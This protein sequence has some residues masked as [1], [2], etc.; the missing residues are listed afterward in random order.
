MNA[1]L[2]SSATT[3]RSFV[4]GTL[5]AGVA[6]PVGA[7]NVS[8]VSFA[9]V[10]PLSG[11]WARGGQLLLAGAEMAVEEINAAGGIR[12]LNGAKV[13]LVSADAGD[14]PEKAKSAIQRLISQEPRLI[15]G[16]GAWLSSFTLAVTEVT[17]RERLPWLTLSYADPVTARG[18]RYV[19]QTSPTGSRISA[20]SIPGLLGVLKKSGA[21]AI[22][23][24]AIVADNTPASQS[25]AKPLADTI[26]KANGLDLVA[27]ETYSPPLSDA[28]AIVRRVRSAAADLAILLTSNV[29]DMKLVM[30]KMAEFKINTKLV[31]WGGGGHLGSPELGQNINPGLLDGL[32]F[33]IPNWV[34]KGQ[35]Q[36]ASKFIARSKEPFMSQDPICGY[37]D[38]WILKDA[39]E[40]AGTVDRTMIAEQMHKMNLMDGPA[41][42]AY[43]G[44]VR[45]AENG[46]REGARVLLVQWQGGKPVVVSPPELATGSPLLV[47]K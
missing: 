42:M 36:L 14:S 5:A 25:F 43:P 3:R 41:A 20:E 9:V 17:E 22:G 29:P 10:A 18:Y 21:S 16:T 30:E 23:K 7:A 45:F 19:F 31:M 2:S 38:M 28:T 6:G 46:L 47:R 37:G 8:D 26:L 11:P 13:K 39:V 44:G 34:T 40:L 27:N 1:N 12:A 35:E 32:F 24:V 15:G 4:L 33:S